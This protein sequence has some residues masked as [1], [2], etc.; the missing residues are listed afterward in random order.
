MQPRGGRGLSTRCLARSIASTLVSSGLT[1]LVLW[2]L[3][4]AMIVE[5]AV[6][7]TQEGQGD[8]ALERGPGLAGSRPEPRRRP[9]LGPS[10]FIPVASELALGR[11]SARPGGRLTTFPD[12]EDA[13][14]RN[15]SDDSALRCGPRWGH[16]V[17]LARVTPS[18]RPRLPT[19]PGG[20]AAPLRGRNGLL[21]GKRGRQRSALLRARTS[22]VR[23]RLR[24]AAQVSCRTGNRRKSWG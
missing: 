18:A 1:L 8:S 17:G 7:Q 21:Q 24:R 3:V 2:R 10:G 19:A 4:V 14:R 12:A 16:V 22:Q 20:A 6:A 15:P 11:R 23:E 9:R 5:I 13:P